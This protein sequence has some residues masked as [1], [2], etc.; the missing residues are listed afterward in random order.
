MDTKMSRRSVTF[1]EKGRV[2][3]HGDRRLATVREKGKG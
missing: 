1:A 2:T 3:E